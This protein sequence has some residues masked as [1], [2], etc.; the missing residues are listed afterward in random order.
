MSVIKWNAA[1]IMKLATEAG[2]SA[3]TDAALIVERD[4]KE[5]FTVS[6]KLGT[7]KKGKKG[8][9]RSGKGAKSK[10]HYPSKPGQAPAVDYGAYRASISHEVVVKRDQVHAFVGSDT[11]KL[12]Q[13]NAKRRGISAA[14]TGVGSDLDYGFY[15]E[16][17][18]SKM[19]P[20]PHLRP[21]VKRMRRKILERLRRAYA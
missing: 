16:E 12:Q 8:T 17:G 3:M 2:V 6:S 1:K 18:T 9:R 10:R 20:R 4:V 15:L 21:A 5:N 19:E 7:T 13:E 14:K 11:K